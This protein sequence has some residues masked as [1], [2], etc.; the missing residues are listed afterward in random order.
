MDHEVSGIFPPLAIQTPCGR[1]Q[2]GI[3]F[4][5]LQPQKCPQSEDI[6]ILQ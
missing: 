3:Q 2:V 6:Y 4:N 1:R 5:Y